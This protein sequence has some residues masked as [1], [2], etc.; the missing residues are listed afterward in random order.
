MKKYL[1]SKLLISGLMA[2]LVP[3][4]AAVPALAIDVTSCT[5]SPAGAGA[6]QIC[7]SSD[8]QFLPMITNVINTMIF[9]VGI[10]AVIM[11]IV[12]GISAADSNFLILFVI[13]DYLSLDVRSFILCYT[14]QLTVC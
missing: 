4:A 11:I 3:A 9:I 5:G 2:V 12:G 8:E 6:K 14:R 7:G 13:S 10:I 1:P